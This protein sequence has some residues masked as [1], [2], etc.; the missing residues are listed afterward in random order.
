MSTD[1]PGVSLA[2]LIPPPLVVALF[3]IMM[4]VCAQE[5]GIGR[6]V[7]IWPDLVIGLLLGGG[8]LLIGSA[9]G[10]LLRARTT[11]NPLRP[12]NASR[13]VV[14]GV[15][16]WSRNP[17]YLGDL[18]LLLAWF[19]WL[20][21]LANLLLLAGYVGYMNRFQIMPEERILAQRFGDAY[22]NYCARVRRWI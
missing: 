11:V 19:M 3:G 15:F 14:T 22:L 7:L 16:R 12:G 21:Q 2:L 8:L 1:K 4:W 9:A 20:G 18:L 10:A 17:I 5:F 13:L 6:F